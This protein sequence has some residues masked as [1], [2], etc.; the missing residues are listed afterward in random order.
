MCPPNVEVTKSTVD[1]TSMGLSDS[2]GH[3][4]ALDLAEQTDA[5]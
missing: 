1:A 4:W 5:H 2:D 3:V